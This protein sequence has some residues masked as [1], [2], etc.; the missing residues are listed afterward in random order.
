M[1][2]KY[3][4]FKYKN[5]TAVFV[6]ILFAIALSRIGPFHDFLTHLGGFGYLGA[7][8]AGI[9]FVWIFTVPTSLLILL[10][11]TE[12]LSPIEIGLI[13]GLGAVV[14]DLIIFKFVRNRLT[15]ELTEI[16]DNFGGSYIKRIFH[17]KYFHWTL[18]IIGA[19][20]IA[21]PF[22]DELGVSLMGITKMKTAHF[23][24]LSFILNS[25]GI[26]FF[27]ILGEIF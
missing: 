10:T 20:I 27:L 1:I 11:L 25:L 4:N 22:P 26:Y 14:G 23:I 2:D 12:Y 13:G 24:I 16:Y 3:K 17:S 9:L 15:E 18:P 6:G 21:S 7:F 19:V 5:L 8:L